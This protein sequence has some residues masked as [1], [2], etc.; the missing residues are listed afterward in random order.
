MEILDEIAVLKPRMGK[1]SGGA[2]RDRVGSLRGAILARLGA[3]RAYG[4][5]SKDAGRF[6][7][8]RRP[9]ARRVVIKAHVQRLT[10]RGARAA[11][12]H[13]RYIER[14]GVER[15]GSKGV[16]YGADGP[17][18]RE[19]FEQPRVDEQHQFRF[20]VSPEDA[21]ELDLTAYV[22]GLMDRVERDVGRKI[23]WAAVNHYDTAHPHAHIVVRGVARDGHEL[24]FDRDYIASGMRWR[25]Q[26]LATRELGPRLEQDVR[27][28]RER[29]VSQERFTSLDR[30]IERLADAAGQVEGRSLARPG[31]VDPSILRARLEHLEVLGL[32]ERLSRSDW[33]LAAGWQKELQELG[34]RGDIIKQ[35]H[36]AMPGG[37]ARYHVVE[38]DQP[39]PDLGQG[40]RHVGR[41][42]A[43]GLSDEV[44]GTFYAVIETPS[45]EAYH[46]KLDA[47]AAERVRVGAIVS[48]ENQTERPVGT[49]DRQIAEIAQTWGGVLSRDQVAAGDRPRVE[50]RLRELEGQK[51]VRQLR[52]DQ[53]LVPA[54]FMERLERQTSREPPKVRLVVQ[55]LSDSLEAQV[56]HRGPVWLDTVREDSL[57]GGGFGAELAKALERRRD[58]LRGMGIAPGD[59]NKAVKLRELERLAV[60]KGMIART[61][62]PQPPWDFP[63]R[64]RVRDKDPD[65]GR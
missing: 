13:L 37:A 4:R 24:R 40:E 63:I 12:L 1:R 35:I 23:E 42:A 36:E 62:P 6:A 20:I 39:L 64:S 16:L 52:P 59:P 30:E 25:A 31:R 55:P 14:D 38:P 51:L 2:A 22:R 17:V 28:A 50:R 54:D 3:T 5:R 46:A 61:P 47:R 7:R 34:K 29:E 43:K 44:K 9:D 53:W 19:T 56:S 15:D 45:G 8:S 65:R 33:S 18:A 32:A 60:G 41:V 49:V 10:S 57:G 48:L 26:E 21:A 58:A 11:K 27:R